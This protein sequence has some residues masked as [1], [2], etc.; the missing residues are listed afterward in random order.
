M[1]AKRKIKTE[2]IK[3]PQPFAI[4]IEN[5]EVG[6]WVWLGDR[7]MTVRGV[8]VEES[9]VL[10]GGRKHSCKNVDLRWVEAKELRTRPDSLLR[11][12]LK[13]LKGLPPEVID[14]IDWTPWRK[15]SATIA[16]PGSELKI[17]VLR[18]RVE[19]EEQLWNTNDCRTRRR[20]GDH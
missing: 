19:R 14:A 6:D 3:K 1:K 20:D 5:L 18:L 12:K 4:D 13:T 16:P 11:R 10:V 15:P 8:N 2:E 17:E 7:R 9:R